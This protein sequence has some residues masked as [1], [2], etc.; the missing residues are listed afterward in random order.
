V[1]AALRL[2][3]EFLA[4]LERRGVS[5]ARIVHGRGTGSLRRTV[6]SHLERHPLVSGCVTG[7]RGTGD[8]GATIVHLL[9]SEEHDESLRKHLAEA[10]EFMAEYEE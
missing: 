1:K 5:T 7:Y 6:Q 3:D 4:D 8:A 2:I 10:A 9:G